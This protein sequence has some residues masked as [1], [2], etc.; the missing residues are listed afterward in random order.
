MWKL[1]DPVC[2]IEVQDQSRYY[3]CR[4]FSNDDTGEFRFFGNKAVEQLGSDNIL[5]KL[6]KAPR[7]N[8]LNKPTKEE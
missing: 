7:K 2:R 3:A 1:I 6:N 4:V 5:E 8:L